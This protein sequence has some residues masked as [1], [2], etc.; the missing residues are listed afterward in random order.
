MNIDLPTRC[1]IEYPVK[2]QEL[3]YGS[4]VVT[5]ALLGVVWCNTFDLRPSKDEQTKSGVSVST[6]KTRWQARYRTDIN[7]GMR[8]TINSIIYNIVGGPVELGKHE[9][10]ECMLERY[11]S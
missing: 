10:I 2:T 8:M 3:T 11:S 4:D 1:R 5:W 9:Y 7:T 6:I